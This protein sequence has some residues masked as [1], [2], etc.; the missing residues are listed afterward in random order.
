[1]ATLTETIQ[2]LKKSSIFGVLFLIIAGLLILV[3]FTNSPRSQ[4]QKLLPSPPPN[5][6]I[7]QNPLQSQPQI[8]NTD[9]LQN[10][11]VP[12]Q[13][14]TYQAIKRNIGLAE[15]QSLATKL[16][17]TPTSPRVV[18]NT[19]DGTLFVWNQG[20]QTLNLSQSNLRYTNGNIDEN[21]L[22]LPETDII[23]IGQ[24]FLRSLILLDPDL[25]L[26]TPK[27]AYLISTPV[28]LPQ[29]TN[30]FESANTIE[31]HFEKK[32]DGISL[33]TNSPRSSYAILR[34]TKG[35]EVTRLDA[36][37]FESFNKKQAFRT[38]TL[39]EA[40]S[41]V[42]A[43][44]G[45]IVEAV[46]L[47]ENGQSLELFQNLPVDL[48]TVSLTKVSFGYFLPDTTDDLVQPIYVFEGNFVKDN[49]NGRVVIYVPSL[50]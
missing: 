6:P 17:I 25:S 45:S 33:V 18:E 46:I 16:L 38:K 39:K 11:D 26:N 31:L 22:N 10:I 34:I 15:A 50:K 44:Q 13:L 19:Q 30:S 37:L 21:L 49:Q 14:A 42:S 8:I 3:I 7:K 36:K 5:P 29:S 41:A 9:R 35:G 47:D 27:T 43:R 24:D 2:L 32:L 40:I 20:N 1:M 28:A 12:D 48:D 4:D 23:N